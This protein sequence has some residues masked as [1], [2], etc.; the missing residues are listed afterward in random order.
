MHL[1]SDPLSLFLSLSSVILAFAFIIGSA[2]S[3][4]FEG[5]LFI[6]VRRPYGIGDIIHISN[7]EMDTSPNGYAQISWW[8]GLVA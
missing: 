3:K 6:L 7:T 8:Q 1:F 4:Y 5:I 2:S